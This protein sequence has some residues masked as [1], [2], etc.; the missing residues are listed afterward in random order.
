MSK[1]PIVCIPCN[2]IDFD[3]LKAQAVRET[4]IRA[5]VEV[6]G[7]NPLLVPSLVDG[8]EAAD[9]AAR[10]DGFLFTGA[11]SHVSPKCYGEPQKFSDDFLDP[12]RDSTT[13]PLLRV[14]QE[15]DKPVIAICR[16][17]QELNVSM[18]GTLNQ[19]IHESEG[20]FDHRGRADL[21]PP[22]IF[23]YQA[24][25]VRRENGGWFEKI[26][27]PAEFTVNSIHEQGIEKLADELQ[28]EAVSDDGL[29]EAVSHRHKRFIVGT[30]W[31][32][33]GDW[34]INPS[35]RMLFEAFGSVLRS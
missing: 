20:R 30:Q 23:E 34:H 5:L 18:G 15:M 6:S 25:K 4:Y 8:I 7:C 12:A 1:R 27:I 3:G 19:N 31:H 32:P 14:A 9:L 16:G 21:K 2:I 28:I 11:R 17:F 22:E 35:S 33:E 13:I 10:V 24:H 26:G 29:V